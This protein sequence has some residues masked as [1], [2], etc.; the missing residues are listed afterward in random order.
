MQY[1]RCKCGKMWSYG[2]D[3][4][5][6]CRRCD[7]CGMTLAQHP[8]GHRTPNPHTWVTQ[9]DQNTGEPYEVCR[10]CTKIRDKQG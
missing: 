2:S 7:T 10:I 5:K 3:G 8:D 4:P 1:Y 6:A 9:Y